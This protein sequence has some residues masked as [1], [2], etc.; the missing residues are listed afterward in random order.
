MT[1][2]I[3]SGVIMKS[4]IHFAFMNCIF[5]FISA[6]LFITQLSQAQQGNI[7]I[8]FNSFE[9]PQDTIGW[10]GYG[11]REFRND[12]PPS[13]GNQS[14]YISGGCIV[15]HAWIELGPFEEDGFFQL[16]C[17]GKDLAIGGGIWLE[18]EG[19]YPRDQIGMVINQKEWKYYESAETLFCLAGKKIILSMGAGGIA[20]SAMLVDKVEIVNVQSINTQWVIRNSGTTERLTDVVMLDSTTAIVVGRDGSIMKTTDSGETWRNTAPQ[21]DCIPES[22]DCIMRWNNTSFYDSLNG[23][24]VGKDII[25]TTNGGEEWQFL[26]ISVEQEFLSSVFVEPGNIYIGDDSGYVHHSIDSGKTWSSERITTLPIRSIYPSRHDPEE[27]GLYVLEVFALTPHSLFMKTEYPSTD[28]NEMPL[29]YFQGLG[30]EAFKGEFSEDGTAFIVG[31]GGDFV[32]LP[33]ITR[34]RPPDSHWYSVGPENVFWGG[35]LDLSIP[36]S[37]IIYASGINGLV[38]KSSNNGDDWI[39][40]NTPTSSSLNSIYFFDNERGFA[41]GDSG[42]ILYTYTGG[43]SPTNNPPLPFHLLTPANEDSMQIM[44]SISFTWQKVVDPDNNPILYTLLISGDSCATWNAYGPVSDTVL[45]VHS[46]AQIPGR[47][48][49]MV[50]ANDGM[51]ATP[52]LDVFAFN[53]FSVADVGESG[54]VP[55]AF[56]LSQNYPNPFNPTTKIKFVIPNSSFVNLKVYDV[57]GREVTTLVNEEKPA[58]EYEVEFSGKN[59]SS[60]VY[61]YQLKADNYVETKKMLFIK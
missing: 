7:V 46:P 24:V 50:I 43:V 35:L 27:L 17:W 5:F 14:L 25:V 47:Y 36:S 31:V 16:R 38:L 49:W 10:Q 54:D 8:Y 3:L 4:K 32:S 40:L 21:I 15:S 12:V 1:R 30:S 28:W 51:L 19:D 13:G 55:G 18:E 58:G 29:D 52:S 57:L 33:I 44:R 61:H 45:Q 34:L 56:V 23:I 6:V 48:F 60:G 2:K 41:V 11:A 59:L 20:S 26:N 53:I 42:T 37:N 9:S 22:E 39:S